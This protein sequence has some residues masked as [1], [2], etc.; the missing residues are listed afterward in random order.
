MAD[1][2]K[3]EARRLYRNGAIS[4]EELNSVISAYSSKDKS[5]VKAVN[6]SEEAQQDLLAEYA[7][8]R[9]YRNIRRISKN[10]VFFFWVFIVSTLLGAILFL[11]E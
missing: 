11:A 8:S 2:F 1:I 3:E 4:Q 9:M 5:I 6:E 10:V 7:E